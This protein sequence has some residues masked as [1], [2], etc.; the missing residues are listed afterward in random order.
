MHFAALGWQLETRAMWV[1]V[2]DDPTVPSIFTIHLLFGETGRIK[3][4]KHNTLVPVDKQS[5]LA[6]FQVSV[7]LSHV[8]KSQI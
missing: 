6:V 5:G 8:L 2:L 4:T 1:A 3:K 7:T